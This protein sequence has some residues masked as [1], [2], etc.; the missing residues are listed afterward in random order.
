MVITFWF[1]T[2]TTPSTVTPVIKVEFVE[3]H[4]G[5]VMSEAWSDRFVYLQPYLIET[6][7]EETVVLVVEYLDLSG[8]FGRVSKK[9][10]CVILVYHKRSD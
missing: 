10:Q 4:D 6:L 7:P 2:S 9:I 1:K 3:D 5:H 8:L